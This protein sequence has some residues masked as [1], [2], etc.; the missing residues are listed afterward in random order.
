[1]LIL[2]SKPSLLQ[3]LGFLSVNDQPPTPTFA[4]NSSAVLLCEYGSSGLPRPFDGDSEEAHM[5]LGTAHLEANDPSETVEELER[6]YELN[7]NPRQS[8]PCEAQQLGK[9]VNSGKHHPTFSRVTSRLR[10]SNTGSV[11]CGSGSSRPSRLTVIESR[12]GLQ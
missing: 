7:P 2:A 6:A 5:M 3:I 9:L 10:A 12:T 11:G 4:A 1:M 8:M